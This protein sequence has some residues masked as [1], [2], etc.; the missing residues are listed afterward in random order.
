MKFLLCQRCDDAW[1]APDVALCTTCGSWP[2]DCAP[3]SGDGVAWYQ[4]RTR[5]R[6]AAIEM[7]ALRGDEGALARGIRARG[8]TRIEW[9]AL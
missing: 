8:R 1:T 4:L 7:R 9:Y 5:G 3:W 2:I 6:K